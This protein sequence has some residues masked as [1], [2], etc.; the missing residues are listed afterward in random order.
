MLMLWPP[1]LFV[2]FLESNLFQYQSHGPLNEA[3]PDSSDLK[4]NGQ[5]GRDPHIVGFMV[6]ASRSSTCCFGRGRYLSEFQ[7]LVTF[8]GEWRLASVIKSYSFSHI[9]AL[10]EHKKSPLESDH[11]V[12]HP[13]FPQWSAKCLRETHTQYPSRLAGPLEVPFRY[14]GSQWLLMHLSSKDWSNPPSKLF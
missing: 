3:L 14:Y 2:L 13:I 11:V 4:G 6:G 1:Q 12:E 8:R 10:Q 7:H 5:R 9:S